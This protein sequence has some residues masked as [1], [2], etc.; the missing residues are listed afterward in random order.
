VGAY[1][2]FL[3]VWHSPHDFTLDFAVTQPVQ[4][5]APGAPVQVPCRVVWRG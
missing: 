2:N 3:T 5:T 4:P 1:A